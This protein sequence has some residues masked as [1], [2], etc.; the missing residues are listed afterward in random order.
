V[1]HESAQI[2]VTVT[3]VQLSYQSNDDNTTWP[4]FCVGKALTVKCHTARRDV[5]KAQIPMTSTQRY[6]AEASVQRLH[7]TPVSHQL[8][9]HHQSFVKRATTLVHQATIISQSG[10]RH[11]AK[12]A[13]AA[14]A[15]TSNNP[16]VTSEPTSTRRQTR[17][18]C[19]RHS[20]RHSSST[21]HTRRQA[22]R[23]WGVGLR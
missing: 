12:A 1:S 21:G 8:E 23:Y 11:N 15:A 6:D 4:A 3:G 16:A 10:A 18:D 22:D 9:G 14:S 13:A 17:P 20:R 19:G 5:S 7:F 2:V